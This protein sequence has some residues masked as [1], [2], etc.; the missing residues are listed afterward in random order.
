MSPEVRSAAQATLFDQMFHSEENR[1][2]REKFIADLTSGKTAGFGRMAAQQ[3]PEGSRFRAMLYELAGAH[4][5]AADEY[6]KLGVGATWTQGMTPEGK[7]I[8]IKQGAD[9]RA[10]EAIDPT[11]NE[12]ITDPK[13]LQSLNGGGMAGAKAGGANMQYDAPDGTTHVINEMTMPNGTKRYRDATTNQWLPSLPAN[14]R[15]VG[16]ENPLEKAAR[17]Q[18]DR[19]RSRLENANIQARRQGAPLPFSPQEIERQ[20]NNV[21]TGVKGGHIAPTDT[22][23]GTANTAPA[24][25]ATALSP[26]LE[27]QAQAIARGDAPMPTGLGTNN[28]RN[29]AI[30]NRVY[31]I[32]PNLDTGAYK[33]TQEGRKNWTQPN[34][35]GAQQIQQFDRAASHAVAM[36][37][38]IDNLGNTN[39]PVWNKVANDY[40]RNTGQAAPVDFD[41]AKKIVSDEVMK[42]VLGSNAGT[43]AEREA[44]Q[45]DFS[46]AS[47][48]AQLKAVLARARDLM[49][50]QGTA[51]ERSYKNSTK[52]EDFGNRLG[53]AG[54]QLLNQGRAK[55]RA[56]AQ[57]NTTI[58]S[59]ADIQAEIERRKNKG[60]Q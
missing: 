6:N 16:Q 47:S 8:T 1:K 42:T 43:G 11:T 52:L 12:R 50:A 27:A 33:V 51:M 39:L 32:N 25:T 23:S 41:M 45:H 40:L 29:Q 18:A 13:V 59:K 10:I 31:E 3:T 38:V 30:V 34:G 26:Q 17:M 14:V 60:N 28:L 37:E 24:N 57:Q 49:S 56:L 36:D 54:Q 44:L 58:P 15:H 7:S 35:K 55:D 48:P 5:A 4:S 2:T 20:V 53:P 19:E 22:E 21:Y 9:G 46:S